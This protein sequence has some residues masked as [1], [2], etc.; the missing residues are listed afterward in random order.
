MLVIHSVVI[1]HT[2]RSATQLFIHSAS[3]SLQPIVSYKAYVSFVC[4]LL[5]N[6]GSGS[7]YI[8]LNDGGILNN[9]LGRMWS[10]PHVMYNYSIQLVV[11][12][13]T[14]T[15]LSQDSWYS[16]Q[17]LNQ[18]L[19]KYKLQVVSVLSPC[20][21]QHICNWQITNWT[22]LDKGMVTASLQEC[23][24]KMMK[25]LAEQRNSSICS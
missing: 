18:A 14:A 12:W 11:L 2:W 1:C 5:N 15:N 10:Q 7:D 13:K 21:A 16:G 17:D 25:C 4:S 20:Q 24:S 6:S 9:E 8:A 3:D 23:L 19:P 22:W